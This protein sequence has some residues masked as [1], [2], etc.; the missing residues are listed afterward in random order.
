MHVRSFV[1]ERKADLEAI[2]R[3]SSKYIRHTFLFRLPRSVI[4]FFRVQRDVESA[5]Q[6]WR[7][8]TMLV[9]TPSVDCGP[10]LLM[11]QPKCFQ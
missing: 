10:I 7:A 8:Q 3:L 11:E 6:S 2:F 1:L 9:Y 4:G 5:L